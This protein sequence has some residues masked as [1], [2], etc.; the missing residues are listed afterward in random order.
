M[1]LKD[2]ATQLTFCITSLYEPNGRSLKS[3][4]L[5][6]LH[7]IH[8]WCSPAPWTLIGDFNLTRFLDEHERREGNLNDI[9]SFNNLI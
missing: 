5:Q 7:F 2:R 8:A 6:D 3:I 4:F 9:D 1:K